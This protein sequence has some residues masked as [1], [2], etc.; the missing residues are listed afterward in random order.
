MPSFS[1]EVEYAK[2]GRA[3]CKK[4]KGKIDKDLIRVGIKAETPED[5]EGAAAHFGCSWHHFE[6]FPAAKGQAW[7][8][9]HLTPEVASAVTGLDSLKS[10]DR[11]IVVELFKSCRGEVPVPVAPLAAAA[12]ANETPAKPSKKRKSKGDDVEVAKAPKLA[13]EPVLSEAQMAAIDEAKT[14][15]ASKNAAF[16]GSVLAKNGLPK[17]GRKD[18]LIDRVAE[19]QVLGVPP[20]C[21]VCEKK[22]LLWS[23]ATGKFSCSGFFDEE[24]KAF[25][26]CKGPSTAEIVRSL[27][28]E[29]GA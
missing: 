11:D 13:A 20:T 28:Q 4:C 18:E 29:L 25:K 12:E 17:T 3:A 2:S 26:K 21:D 1:F 14:K 10:E 5:A 16:L 15:L 9:K 6:C 23:R 8:K 22:K 7:F 24:T 27:W 19:N